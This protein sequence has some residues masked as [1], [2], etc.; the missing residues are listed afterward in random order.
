MESVIMQS[1]KVAIINPIQQALNGE[2]QITLS[3]ES[4][5]A[6]TDA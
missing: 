2:S 1:P 6:S 3:N 4:Q 5:G